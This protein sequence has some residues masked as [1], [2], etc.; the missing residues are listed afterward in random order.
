MIQR[1]YGMEYEHNLEVVAHRLTLASEAVRKVAPV[2]LTEVGVFLLA[3]ASRDYRAKSKR[4]TDK[5]GNSWPMI[6]RAAIISRF[7]RRPNSPY[8]KAGAEVDRL[9]GEEKAVLEDLRRRLPRGRNPERA[10]QRGAI[11]SWWFAET[12]EG[13]KAS[14]LRKRINTKRASRRGMVD[15]DHSKAVIGVD[16]GRLVNSLDF[17]KQSPEMLL[18]ASNTA[19]TIGTVVQYAKHFD[20]KRAIIASNFMTPARVARC[21]LIMT[22]HVEKLGDVG[23]KRG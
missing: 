21:G 12:K 22:K 18:Q 8:M 17:K 16:T 13:Q 1:G 3:E 6:T 2:A 9:R 19:V 20:A 5:A 10:R 15:R 7:H 14:K 4:Q 23:P 11:A